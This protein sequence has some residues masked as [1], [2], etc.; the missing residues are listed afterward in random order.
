MFTIRDAT[1]EKSGKRRAISPL[2][3]I[4]LQPDRGIHFSA[5]LVLAMT[6]IFSQL[7]F[8]ETSHADRT[9]DSVTLNESTTSVTV[10]TGAAI[11]A[12]VTVT[13]SNQNGKNWR[14]I[15]WGIATTTPNPSAMSCVDFEPDHTGQGTYPETFYIT[16]PSVAGTYNAYF[17]AYDND[18]CSSGA[19]TTK[20]ITDAVIVDTTAPTCFFDFFNRTDIAST[21]YWI[22]ANEGGAFGDPRIV[23]DRLRLTDNRGGAS[24]M[25]AL[26]QLFPASGNKIVVEFDH[27]AYDGSGADGMCVV[28]SD[29]SIAPLPGAFGGSLGYAPKQASAGGDTTHPGFAGGWL[30]VALDEYGNFSNPTEGRTGGPGQRSDS[31]AVRGSGSLYTGY[32]YLAGT[33]T[34]SPGIDNADATSP[35]PGYRYRIIIDHLD[36]VHAWTSVERNTGSGYTTLIGCAPGQ[37]SGCTPLDAK[38]AAGQAAVPANWYLS[39]TGS[40]GGETNI[41]DFDNLQVCSTQPQPLPTLDHVRILHDGQALTCAA[42]TISLLACADASCST[43][44]TGPV[45]VNL[46]DIANAKWSSDSITFS[47]G[48]TTVTLTKKTAGTVTLGGTVTSPDVTTTSAICYIGTTQNCALTYTLSSACFDAVEVDRS[49][50]TPIYTKLASTPFSLDVLT[51]APLSGNTTQPVSVALVDPTATSGNCSDFNTGLTAEQTYTFNR[52]SGGR[53][54]FSFTYPNA[55]Q[56]V[57]VR[58][59]NTS[60]NQSACSSDNFAIRPHQLTL[61]TTTP[62]NPAANTI[63]AGADFNLTAASGVTAGYTGTPTT[64]PAKIVDHNTIAIGTG[65]LTGAFA[66]ATGTTAIGTFQYLDVGTITLNAN[67]VLDATFTAVDQVTGLVGGVDH[68]A[69]GDCIADS[70]SNIA[71]VGFYG[72]TIGG[73]ALGPLGRFFPDHYEVTATLTGACNPGTVNEFTYMG[74]PALGVNLTIQ[75]MASAGA[76]PLS[77]YT[78]GY[79]FLAEFNVIGDNSGAAITPLNSRLTPDLPAFQW[80]SGAYV[81]PGTYSFDRAVN[82]D[83]PFDNFR[84]NITINDTDGAQITR[85]N[86]IA[87]TGVNAVLSPATK[88]RYGRLRLPNAYGPET[89]ALIIPAPLEFWNGA[90]FVLNAQDNCTDPGGIA[91][92]RLDNTL[93][94]NQTDGTILINGAAATTLTINPTSANAGLINLNFSPP[95]PGATG[96]TDVTALITASLPWLLFEWEGADNDFND[97]PF[98]R[99]NFGIYRGNDRIINW[100]EIIR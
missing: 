19:S 14:S 46:T 17:I 62:L 31:V 50:S 56:N 37:T 75:A 74:Q 76:T 23:N 4:F 34:L 90:N 51:L 60:T 15:R 84:L 24:T 45:T 48:Q 54:T 7:V 41:H 73:T 28:L 5:L 87:I 35:A 91:N 29:A 81:G 33:N 27:Y 72:C 64:D 69:G 88:I 30:G 32:A 12:K 96:F 20:T 99:V 77:R 21:G 22:V 98:A 16:A 52:F 38:A 85:L 80:S 61:A 25:A 40:T 83:G 95:G 43:L 92:Y 11:S 59:R 3:T 1:T 97:T 44:F 71:S 86:G 63:K 79:A 53:H 57:R 26:R 89:G 94:V 100:R 13:T 66:A 42:E 39:F 47:G 58:I 55:A 6:I 18:D 68:G 65:P 82:P 78:N 49:A 67:A 8:P 93:E 36:G 10:P 2:T 70:A 9:I